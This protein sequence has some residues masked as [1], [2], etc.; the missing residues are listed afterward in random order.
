MN[1]RSAL[2]C[3]IRRRSIT[4]GSR[5]GWGFRRTSSTA[6][7]W[8]R[9][10]SEGHRTAPRSFDSAAARRRT[11][12]ALVFSE[13]PERSAGQHS[14]DQRADHRLVLLAGHLRHD[15]A[16]VL[17]AGEREGSFVEADA[18][19]AVA[20]PGLLPAVAKEVA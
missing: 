12:A 20:L 10:N 17:I 2:C 11:A 15:Q 6:C 1:V 9:R 8:V 14:P 18:R 4:P 5:V 7:R 13:R 19:A 16:A 3:S